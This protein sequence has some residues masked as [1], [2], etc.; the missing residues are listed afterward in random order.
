MGFF[1]LDHCA[2][3]QIQRFSLTVKSS[4]LPFLEHV[5]ENFRC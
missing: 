1:V 5:G 4:E 3:E 2:S